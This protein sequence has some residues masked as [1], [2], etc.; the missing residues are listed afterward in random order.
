MER[1]WVNTLGRKYYV[2]NVLQFDNATGTDLI[3]KG[4]ARKYSGDYPPTEKIKVN[5]KQLKTWY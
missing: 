2:G 5:L 3:S 1:S 4:I